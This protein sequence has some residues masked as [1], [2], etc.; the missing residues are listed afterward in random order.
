MKLS[1][2]KKSNFFLFLKNYLITFLLVSFAVTC[3]TL[4]FL[5]K[6][7]F[8]VDEIKA[9]A[10]VTFGNI[11]LLTA[12]ICVLESVIRFVF[13]ELPMKR[14]LEA[15]EKITSGDFSARVAEPKLASRDMKKLIHEFNRMAQE[16]EGL[17]TLRTDFISNVSHEIKTPLAVI[18]NYASL[19]RTSDIDKVTK[20]EYAERI[21]ESSKRLSLLVSNILKLNRL[22]N[23]KIFPPSKKFNLSE[24]I[25]ESVIQFESVW[26]EKNIE[27]DIN[28]G[29]DIFICS[30]PD[31][32]TIVWNNLLSNAFKFTEN[33][34]KITV[35]LTEETGKIIF[36]V[37]DTGCGM[38]QKTGSHI[39]E[40]FYQG[41]T[42]H[43][44]L[45]NGLGL[46]LV[47]R[48]I[49]ITGAEI[50]VESTLGKGSTF[51]VTLPHK[52]D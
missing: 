3:S 45:G 43:A 8:N 20:D 4:L 12:I 34:G 26:E 31:L 39:F 38:T 19:L 22:E 46:P 25:C 21:A 23:Q 37:S 51:T 40:K 16:I 41:D 9:G 32:L 33:G 1:H 49:D 36:S 24:Q 47:K 50:S 15:T 10:P 17:E 48:V 6:I 2:S 13:S 44:T 30:D 7:E 52:E 18:Q 5:S 14:I 35:S 11:F 27:I 42:S 29:E 28:V